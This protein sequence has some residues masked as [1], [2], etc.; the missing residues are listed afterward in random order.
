MAEQPFDPN[1][2]VRQVAEAG[3]N[4]R[5]GRGVVGKTSYALIALIAVWGIILGR[6]GPDW[7]LDLAMIGAGLIISA[8]FVWF[9]TASH[10][11]AERNPSLALMEGTEITDYRRVEAAIQGGQ[12]MSLDAPNSGPASLSSVPIKAIEDG[13]RDD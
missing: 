6:V 4:V 8:V 5:F 12:P 2:F 11:F 7:R 1:E 10:S 9:T 13:E 3:R